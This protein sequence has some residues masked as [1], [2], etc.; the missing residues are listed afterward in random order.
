MLFL[1]FH[2]HFYL[3][4]FTALFEANALPTKAILTIAEKTS[5][6]IFLHFKISGTKQKF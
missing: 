6:F 5:F 4:L 3:F 2:T 1:T